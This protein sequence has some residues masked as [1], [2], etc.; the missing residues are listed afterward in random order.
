MWLLRYTWVVSHSN[1]FP[2]T[3]C[4][5]LPAAELW[6]LSGYRRVCKIVSEDAERYGMTYVQRTMKLSGT[7]LGTKI[8]E[9][10][11]VVES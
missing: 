2:M 9:G 1:T 4:I 11:G 8:T 5:M 7:Q 3:S 6:S 10:E